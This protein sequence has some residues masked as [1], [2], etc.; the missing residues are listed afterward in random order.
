M[1]CRRYNSLTILEHFPR[2]ERTYIFAE[3]LEVF[4]ESALDLLRLVMVP[5]LSLFLETPENC[6]MRLLRSASSGLCG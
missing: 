3:M 4:A 5:E 1:S 2:E 6:K